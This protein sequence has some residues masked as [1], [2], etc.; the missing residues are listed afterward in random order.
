MEKRKYGGSGG[1]SR[2]PG[3]RSSGGARGGRS[4]GGGTGGGARGDSRDSRDQGGRGGSFEGKPRF[5]RKKV[6]RLCGDRVSLVDYKETDKI[7]KFMTEKGKILPQRISGNCA[8]HQ[9][10]LARAVKRARHT[11]MIAF[12]IGV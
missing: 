9:R 4:Y 6:C 10:M 1:G 5:M 3:G 2:G 7:L 11:S 8:K 12:Q